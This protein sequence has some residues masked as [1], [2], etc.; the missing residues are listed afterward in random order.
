[1]SVIRA[2]H[3]TF[4]YE[5]NVSPI[6]KDISFCAPEGKITGII[7]PNGSGKTTLIRCISGFLAPQMGEVLLDERRVQHI[8]AREIAKSMALVQQQFVTEY[9]FSVLDIVLTGRNPYVSRLHGESEEDYRIARE[10][11]SQVGIEDLSERSVFEISGGER[12]L[13]MLARAICQSAPVMLLDEPVTGL[14]IRHQ[15][16]FLSTVRHMSRQKNITVLCVL[17]DLNLCLNFC[18]YVLL[19]KNGEIFA[20]GDPREVL[21]KETVE[22]VYQAEVM[23]VEKEGQTLIFPRASWQ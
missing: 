16:Q 5:K 8:S 7:G 21:T 19:L 18:D 13:V 10:S 14:D 9:D 3:I 15:I 4:S 23:L 20:K 17:H 1:M 12:Q 11:L 22:T 6:V 2:D